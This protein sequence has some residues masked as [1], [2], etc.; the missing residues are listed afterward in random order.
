[1]TKQEQINKQ[2]TEE[3]NSKDIL[4]VKEALLKLRSVGSA[5][6]IPVILRKW[7]SSADE[8][9]S[10]ITDILYTLKD[11]KTIPFLI[12]ALSS[13]EFDS[14]RDKIISV[15]WNAGLEPKEYL[16]LFTKIACEGNY[17]ECLEC[18]TVIE[19]LDPPLPAEQLLESLLILKTYF[20]NDKNKQDQKYELVRTIATFVSVRGELEED[21]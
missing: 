10:D 21:Q 9:Q 17:L 16:S 14:Q 5:E 4:V 19:N 6:M 18:L 12:T 1:M 13:E 15:F 8:V 3:L 11:K 2:L 20:A 7:F